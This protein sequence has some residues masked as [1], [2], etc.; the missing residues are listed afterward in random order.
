MSQP[1]QPKQPL[2]DCNCMDCFIATKIKESFHDRDNGAVLIYNQKAIDAHTFTLIFEVEYKDAGETIFFRGVFRNFVEA[3]AFMKSTGFERIT[4]E[5]REAF[6]HTIPNNALYTH[7]MHVFLCVI[8][9]MINTPDLIR[10][11]GE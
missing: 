1:Y 9:P 11:G 10:I 5:D 7:G 8:S 3:E 2:V 6:R 4:D